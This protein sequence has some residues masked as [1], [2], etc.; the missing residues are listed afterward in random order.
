[1][2]KI[3]F[4]TKSDR[5]TTSL[6]FHPKRPW[7][8][9]SLVSG[10]IQL[11]DYRMGTLIYTFDEHK[12]PARGVHFHKSADFFV[13]G[14]AFLLFSGVRTVLFHHE[15]PW[16]L[17]ASDDHTVR[18]WD[19]A[20]RSCISV[21]KGHTRSVM[22]ASF[23]PTEDLILSASLDQTV[24]VWDVGAL[25][26]KTIPP[27]DDILPLSQMIGVDGIVKYVLQ[28]HE[29][30]V[31]W[32]SFHP[33]MPVIVSGAED[34]QVKMWHLTETKA[35][36]VETLQG[37]MNNV[38][39][40]MFHAKQ[41]MIL[42]I[43]EDKSIRAWDATERTGLQTLCREH[44][45]F[46]TLAIHPE[47]NL[48]AAGHDSGMII[49]KLERERPAFALSR[50]SI[51]YAKDGYL[52]YYEFSTQ[53][54]SKVIHL[55]SPRTIYFS[56][57]DNAAL[58]CSDLAGGSYELYIIPKD[59]IGRSEFVLDA[60]KG[61]GN[62]AVFIS[63][64][65]F[66]VFEKSTNQVSVMNLRNKLVMKV[67][68]PRPTD[69]IFYAGTGILL[70]RSEEEVVIVDLRG[71][72]VVADLHAPSVRHVVWSDDRERVALL[73]KHSIII[74]SKKLEQQ[75]SLHE[76]IRVKS[77]VWDE[78]GV[79]IYTTLRDLKFCLPSGYSGIIQTLDAPIYITKVV[80]NVIFSLDRDGENNSITIDLPPDV[81]VR[82]D[83]EW[84]DFVEINVEGRFDYVE[85]NHVEDWVAGWGIDPFLLYEA[86]N[87]AIL[88]RTQRARDIER[89]LSR[90]ERMNR[91]RRLGRE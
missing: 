9:A 21:L 37:H 47:I 1:M 19:W 15:Y 71:N 49:F 4:E 34:H 76:T 38:S 24:L 51:F 7:I 14:V 88:R 62:S 42:S 43:S 84:E 87:L 66:A 6:S 28:G 86:E 12:G 55:R 80:D 33:T 2:V 39:C 11:W 65:R 23:H 82:V 59:S 68:L 64:D 40:V 10:V 53:R 35:W 25:R 58:I 13:S 31:R 45:R 46:W 29:R 41:D 17:S 44:D 52:W 32:A 50:D 60:K 91:R 20:S 61:I 48:L 30:G 69:A 16:I 83:E 54:D 36:E 73:S 18:I 26:R 75:C 27:T 3:K 85:E 78:N 63:R 67:V 22:C 56:P 8:L 79:F 74:A 70:C 89:E 72:L 81:E 90:Q 57:K 5:V 77:G